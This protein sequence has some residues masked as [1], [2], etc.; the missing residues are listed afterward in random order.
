MQI[1]VF[2]L[3]T[4]AFLFLLFFCRI[5]R[6]DT[7]QE[8]VISLASEKQFDCVA[9]VIEDNKTV[10]SGVLI[11]RRYVLSAAHILLSTTQLFTKNKKADNVDPADF[12][13]ERNDLQGK[14][15]YHT[16][17]LSK[18]WRWLRN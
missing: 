16:S 13:I 17:G 11:S 3:L 10:G 4:P 9:K 7:R 8:A 5:F 2:G 18:K 15:F 1:K 12:K 6:H 14:A